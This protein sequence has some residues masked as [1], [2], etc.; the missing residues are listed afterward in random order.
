M[1]TGPTGRGSLRQHC[2]LAVM[3]ATAAQA[4]P[5][6]SISPVMLSHVCEKSEAMWVARDGQHTHTY[7][8][9]QTYLAREVGRGSMEWG[10]LCTDH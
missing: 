6:Q 2:A 9:K 1:H 3:A 7:L 4:E 5:Y 10:G 8:I